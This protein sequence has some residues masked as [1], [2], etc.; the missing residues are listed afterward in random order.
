MLR[1]ESPAGR[2]AERWPA[3]GRGVGVRGALGPGVASWLTAGVGSALVA[4]GWPQPGSR[5][6]AAERTTASAVI[7][8]RRRDGLSLL[9]EAGGDISREASIARLSERPFAF[10]SIRPYPSEAPLLYRIDEPPPQSQPEGY[11]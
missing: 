10:P 6:A 9:S 8:R 1:V 11:C 7:R 3:L 4:A 5:L 2:G